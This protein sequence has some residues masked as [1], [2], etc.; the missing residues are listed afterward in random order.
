MSITPSQRSF[1]WKIELP[2]IVA[3]LLAIGASLV[4]ANRVWQQQARAAD[5]RRAAISGA[6]AVERAATADHGFY[7]GSSGATEKM[8]V[9]AGYD[10]ADGVQVTVTATADR[11]CVT[12][13]GSGAGEWRQASIG[14][15]HRIRSEGRCP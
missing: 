6:L 5:V 10:G 9:R 11:Y 12:A 14:I 8:L 1:A 4:Y 2:V 7:S 3:V 15:T 13:R